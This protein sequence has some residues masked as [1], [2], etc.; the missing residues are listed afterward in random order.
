MQHGARRRRAACEAQCLKR[1]ALTQFRRPRAVPGCFAWRTSWGPSFNF[2]CWPLPKFC[3][4][5]VW[6]CSRFDL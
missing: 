3:Q 5:V 1:P 2:E 6:S 4:W